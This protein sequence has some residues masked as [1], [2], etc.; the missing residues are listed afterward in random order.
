LECV[1]GVVVVAEGTPADV[2][3]HRAV[4]TYNGCEGGF[5]LVVDEGFEQFPIRPP[6]P[7]L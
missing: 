3:N 7:N 6:R 4:T 2:Q 1:L 5:F